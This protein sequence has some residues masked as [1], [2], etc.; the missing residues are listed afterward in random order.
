MESPLSAQS[1]AESRFRTA[2]I[3]ALVL[4][5]VAMLVLN[6]VPLANNDVWL[7]M[8]VGERIVDTGKIPET[9]LFPFTLVRDNHFNAHEWLVSVIYHGFDRA[10]GLRHL[11]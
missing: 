10:F 11:M 6:V 5:V 7:L 1:D 3:A 9:L 2:T 8:K 4:G